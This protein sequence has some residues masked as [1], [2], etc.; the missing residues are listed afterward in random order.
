MIKKDKLKLLRFLARRR[1]R[2]QSYS[3]TAA[4]PLSMTE[5]N[6]ILPITPEIAVLAAQFSE[7]YLAIRRIG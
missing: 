5:S 7:T 6:T 2:I 3:T 4:H 1:G